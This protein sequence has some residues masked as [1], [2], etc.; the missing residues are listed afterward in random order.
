[1][2]S[3]E[4]PQSIGQMVASILNNL[5]PP[6]VR[7]FQR[8]ALWISIV[9]GCGMLVIWLGGA[10]IFGGYSNTPDTL[11]I[12]EDSTFGISV[13]AFILVMYYYLT[14]PQMVGRTLDTLV[15]EQIFVDGGVVT[16]PR[17]VN[18][19]TSKWIRFTPI[20]LL[21]PILILLGLE[22]LFDFDHV[23]HWSETNGLFWICSTCGNTL[24]WLALASLF[25]SLI[26]TM[27]LLRYIFLKNEIVVF[28][29]HP[30]GSGGYG[31]LARFSL[32]LSYLALIIAAFIIAQ[33]IGTMRRGQLSSE[34]IV[35][36]N[37][38]AYLLIV[39]ALF[40]LPLHQAHRA[41][42]TF[43]TNLINRTS[44][45]FF[46]RHKALL[47]ELPQNANALANQL[48]YLEE[49][50]K[51]QAFNQ[52]YPVWPFNMKVRLAVLAN[53][54]TPLVPTVIGLVVENFS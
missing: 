8:H 20:F 44:A 26:L 3:S 49:L 52:K 32:R 51:L 48:K 47:N 18:W 19:C 6:F 1:M 22:A 35:M 23:R 2:E 40:Y 4:N 15:Q 50:E 11:D 46:E 39:P 12:T 42:L 41:M 29:L 28:P 21:T 5:Y 31:S 36:L 10:F 34:Y 53:A 30:D 33:V 27:L 13:I 14:Y 24:G 38:L 54:I 17:L 9:Y 37:S 43:R 16:H 7:R 45:Q 25:V